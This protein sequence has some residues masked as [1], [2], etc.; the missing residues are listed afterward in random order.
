MISKIKPSLF[1]VELIHFSTGF[2]VNNWDCAEK[3]RYLSE[4]RLY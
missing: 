1:F 2:I 4:K 3:D